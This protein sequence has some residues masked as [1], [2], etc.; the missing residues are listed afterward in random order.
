MST[1]W[2]AWLP[3]KCSH[4]CFCWLTISALSLLSGPTI[5]PQCMLPQSAAWQ[6]FCEGVFLCSQI[7][8]FHWIFDK[9]WLPVVFC[10]CYCALVSILGWYCSGN[11]PWGDTSETSQIGLSSSSTKFC[12]L[13][14]ALDA[15]SLCEPT[16]CG[17]ECIIVSI[18]LLIPCTQAYMNGFQ[19][20]HTSGIISWIIKAVSTPVWQA[21]VRIKASRPQ[22]ASFQLT[23]WPS[24]TFPPNTSPIWAASCLPFSGPPP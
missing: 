8:A 1:R 19:P 16:L 20:Q 6:L 21:C 10:L 2:N 23:L 3:L 9:I 14:L 5:F 18:G 17:L 13:F 12:V 7:T 4:L 15:G 11:I 24:W 22:T